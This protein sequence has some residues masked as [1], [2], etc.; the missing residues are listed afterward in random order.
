[1][2]KRLALVAVLRGSGQRVVRHGIGLALIALAAC[3]S[4]PDTPAAQESPSPAARLGLMTSLPIY[5]PLGAAMEDI[6]GGTAAMPSY[7]QAICQRTNARLVARYC[8]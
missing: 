2:S 1:M 4:A 7:H 8:G 5:W 3:G 6:A